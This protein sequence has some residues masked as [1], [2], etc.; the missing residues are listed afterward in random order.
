MSCCDDK[1]FAWWEVIEYLEKTKSTLHVQ[2]NGTI[3]LIRDQIV[4]DEL[5]WDILGCMDK[6]M[7]KILD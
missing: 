7:R 6:H 5:D 2:S 4:T 1:D 3:V